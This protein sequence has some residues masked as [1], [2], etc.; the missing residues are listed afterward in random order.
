MPHKYSHTMSV[1]CCVYRTLEHKESSW[2]VGVHP[3]LSPEELASALSNSI[4]VGLTTAP[5]LIISDG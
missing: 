2:R 3:P 4:Q 5:S 1:C